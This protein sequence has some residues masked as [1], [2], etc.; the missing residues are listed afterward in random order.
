[1]T[2]MPD[3]PDDD[4]GIARWIAELRRRCA[5]GELLEEIP[6]DEVEGMDEAWDELN[7]ELALEEHAAAIAL[8]RRERRRERRRRAWRMPLTDA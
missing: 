1:V 6:L 2:R 3:P 4:A 7:V 5:A 8:R